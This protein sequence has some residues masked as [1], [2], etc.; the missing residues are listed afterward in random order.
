MEGEQLQAGQLA[1]EERRIRRVAHAAA[2]LEQLRVLAEEARL[3]GV[4]VEER[5]GELHGGGLAGA[6]RAEQP[7]HLAGADLEGEAVHGDDLAALP[8]RVHFPEAGDLEGR[9]RGRV[10]GRLAAGHFRSTCC[11]VFPSKWG[12]GATWTPAAW[13]AAILSFA[14]PFPPEMIAPAWPIRLPGGAVAPAMKPT[15]GLR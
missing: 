6:V 1:R 12:P 9:G 7:D 4:R 13:S 2:D 15:T 3:A 8:R 10:R 14:V 5:Q 11:S